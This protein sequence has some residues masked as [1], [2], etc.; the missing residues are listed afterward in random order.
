MIK[1]IIIP[2]LIVI[3]CKFSFALERIAGYDE[4][5][6]RLELSIVENCHQEMPISDRK[7]IVQLLADRV[8]NNQQITANDSGN[9][10]WSN[11][12][13]AQMVSGLLW[14]QKQKFALRNKQ[15]STYVT[16]FNYSLPFT[17]TGERAVD[18]YPII[19][20]I[21]N[22]RYNLVLNNTN[23]QPGN[24]RLRRTHVNG[25]NNSR[26]ITYDSLP[27]VDVFR[28]ASHRLLLAVEI[29]RRKATGDIHGSIPIS[30]GIVIAKKMIEHDQ[31]NLEKFWIKNREYHFFTGNTTRSRKMNFNSLINVYRTTEGLPRDIESV[32]N[33][34]ESDAKTVFDY[35]DFEDMFGFMRL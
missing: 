32:M 16:N 27:S 24:C 18:P 35:Q 29:T 8:N 22:E 28:T 21:A 23:D 33:Q 26:I 9:A 7:N 30:A 11:K 20:T 19:L 3:F 15:N 4:G 12:N 6:S 2:F 1:F 5:L 34:I 14:I 25:Y 31:E 13:L 10:N 17:E